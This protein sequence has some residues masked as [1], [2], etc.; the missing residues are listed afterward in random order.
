LRKKLTCGIKKLKTGKQGR[1]VYAGLLRALVM[2]YFLNWCSE[3]D[4]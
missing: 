4:G 3:T 2:F 1:E